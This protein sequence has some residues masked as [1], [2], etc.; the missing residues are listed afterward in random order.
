MFSASSKRWIRASRVRSAAGIIFSSE[1][2]LLIVYV[3]ILAHGT[4]LRTKDIN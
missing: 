4:A 1:R 2:E 3:G